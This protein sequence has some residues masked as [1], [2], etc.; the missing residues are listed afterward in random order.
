MSDTAT[1]AAAVDSYL[2]EHLL[3]RD[4][5]LDA[6][7]EDSR[8]AGLPPINV[9]PSQGKLLYLLTRLQR[10]V[11]VLEI[12][13]LAGYST[14]WLA[15]A[16]PPDGTL[17]TLEADP[18]HAE[19]ACANIARAG[20]SDV[21][22]LRVGPALESLAQLVAEGRRP[23]ELIFIDADKRSN[24]EYLLRALELSR[25]GSV[26]IADN[27]ARGGDVLDAASPDPSVRGVRRFLELLAAEPRVS[28][29]AIQTVRRQGLRCLR[30]RARHG[31]SVS[32]RQAWQ[33]S[34]MQRAG[35]VIG[36]TATAGHPVALAR[37]R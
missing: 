34:P 35:S 8:A 19:V 21:V 5:V 31:G 6:A 22:E 4:A 37:A 17:I 36:S 20:L 32:R 18:A 14:I 16:L 10:A 26:I 25:A 23:F 28:A 1:Q 13:T 12:G 2:E 29:T 33:A 27:V 7:L 11:T 30:D 3:G 24:P 15:R 9:P